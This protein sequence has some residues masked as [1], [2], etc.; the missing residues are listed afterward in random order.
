M[1]VSVLVVDYEVI[2]Y[3]YDLCE[4][5]VLRKVEGTSTVFV[6]WSVMWWCRGTASIYC[7]CH[8]VVCSQQLQQPA[9]QPGVSLMME[10]PRAIWSA[11]SAGQCSCLLW[12]VDKHW[13]FL[14]LP[15]F[16][17]PPQPHPHS[18]F[19]TPFQHIFNKGGGG[20]SEELVWKTERKSL[21]P[22]APLI[23]C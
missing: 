23:R 14:F 2:D 4:V 19:P 21:S 6:F 5:Q 8:G 16:I 15:V 18:R 13:T 7:L 22:P 11:E 20:Y 17:Q 9:S 12:P 3:V 1:C 10:I